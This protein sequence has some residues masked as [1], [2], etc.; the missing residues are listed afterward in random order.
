MA[1]AR[2]LCVSSKFFS[3]SFFI[4]IIFQSPREI[5]LDHV[6][7]RFHESAPMRVGI[8]EQRAFVVPAAG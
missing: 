6:E 2:V 5:R 4:E 1:A 7:A 3:I 8:F